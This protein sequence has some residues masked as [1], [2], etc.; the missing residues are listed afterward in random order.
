MNQQNFDDLVGRGGGAIQYDIQG[1]VPGYGGYDQMGQVCSPFGPALG[2]TVNGCPPMQCLPPGQAAFLAA[3]NGMM[4]PQMAPQ[5]APPVAGYGAYDQMG[6]LMPGLNGGGFDPWNCFGPP[7]SPL[8]VQQ[9]EQPA[10]FLRPV[11]PTGIRAEPIGLGCVCIGPCEEA[12]LECCVSDI[13]KV[14]QLVIPSSVAFQLLVTDISVGRT[15][16]LQCGP[17]PASMFTEES[18]IESF[19][20]PT[21]N[22]GDCIS[23]TLKNISQSDVEVCVGARVL[24][25]YYGR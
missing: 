16:F 22:D 18:T 24:T 15:C 12:T 6:Q 23:V 5:M 2:Y 21:A 8:V 17:I 9:V 10:R 11:C 19:D 7:V 1:R 4:A 14:K 25:V 13:T 20:F 3:Q